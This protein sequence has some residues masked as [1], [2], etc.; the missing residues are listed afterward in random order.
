MSLLSIAALRL[1]IMLLAACQPGRA[2]GAMGLLL[3]SL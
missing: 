2:H 1:L 3:F